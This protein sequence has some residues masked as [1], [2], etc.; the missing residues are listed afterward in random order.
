MNSD[1]VSKI[2]GF[3]GILTTGFITLKLLD[4]IDWSWWWVLAPMWIGFVLLGL[5]IIVAGIFMFF[6]NINILK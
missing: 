3:C 6:K 4:R 1:L 2:I 5:L